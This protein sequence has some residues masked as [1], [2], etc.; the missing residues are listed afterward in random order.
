MLTQQSHDALETD[1]VQAR[2]SSEVDLKSMPSAALARLI[3]EVRNEQTDS[4]HAY[5]RAAYDR[6]HNR[7]NR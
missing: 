3:D 5:D 6:A 4:T 7:H 1:P 2:S